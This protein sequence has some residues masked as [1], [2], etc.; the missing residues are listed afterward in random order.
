MHRRGVQSFFRDQ[1][2]YSNTMGHI[3]NS[4]VTLLER[5]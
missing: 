1:A 2:L 5:G 4:H 3:K